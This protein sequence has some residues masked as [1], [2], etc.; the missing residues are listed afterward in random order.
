MHSH[1]QIHAFLHLYY[2]YCIGTCFGTVGTTVQFYRALFSQQ[3]LYIAL[4]AMD[5]ARG[6]K[7]R[8]RVSEKRNSSELARAQYGCIAFCVLHLLFQCK[9]KP[10]Q[11]K[12]GKLYMSIQTHTHLHNSTYILLANVFVYPKDF[13]PTMAYFPCNLLSLTVFTIFL[14]DFL[15]RP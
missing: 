8:E 4:W 5:K 9:S 1:R 15:C 2:T 6:D 7:E 10:N 3:L 11:Y 12:C 14:F 13:A